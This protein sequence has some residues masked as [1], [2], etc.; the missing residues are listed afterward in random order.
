MLK[1]H[2]INV[3]FGKNHIL[4]N[5]SC[6]VESGDFIVIVGTNGAGK[7]TFF[8]TIAGKIKPVSG[9][10]ALENR[11]ITYLNEQQRASFIT[12]IFQNTRLNSV[13]S[14]TTAQNLAIAC[15]SQRSVR[16]VDGMRAMPREKAEALIGAIGMHSSILDKPMGA[17]SGGQRQLIAFVMAMQHIPKILLLD[18]PT[19]ALD[20]Q[21]AT[22]LLYHA[23]GFIK[24]H[25][26]TT[27]LIT[28]DPHIALSLGNKIWIL[29]NGQIV[30][31]YTALEK[32]YL[33]P[34][35]LIGQIDYAYIAA[36]IPAH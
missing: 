20:P 32:Q 4:R 7:S 5:L 34:E 1:L 12:R 13:G 35:Q 25:A 21:S 10:I 29:D 18:E 27:L 31:Q 22:K 17:L 6:E 23:A 14:L 16:F 8:D 15:Y 9:S 11:D 36:H 26:V 33:K 2:D 24:Q 3:W 19:A 30:K 28:H